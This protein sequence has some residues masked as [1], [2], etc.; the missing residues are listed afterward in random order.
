MCGHYRGPERTGDGRPDYIFVMFP[1]ELKKAPDFGAFFEDGFT[2]KIYTFRCAAFT[3][4]VAET[5][6]LDG[7]RNVD[8]N[9][10]VDAGRQVVAVV[11]REGQHLDHDPAL[12]VR[13][14]Q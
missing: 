14:F 7:G 9:Q 5:S 6:V 8:A 1:G 12:A 3:A 13:H 11:T 2:E 10:V 4:S